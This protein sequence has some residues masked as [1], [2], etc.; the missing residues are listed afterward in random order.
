MLLLDHGDD[1]EAFRPSR[2]VR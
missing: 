2:H 1:V